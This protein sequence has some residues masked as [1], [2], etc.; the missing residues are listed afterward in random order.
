MED[1]MTHRESTGAGGRQKRIDGKIPCA[2]GAACKFNARGNCTFG[3][4]PGEREAATQHFY[5]NKVCPRLQKRGA[6]AAHQ[7]GKCLFKHPPQAKVSDLWRRS[8]HPRH[9]GTKP[10]RYGANCELGRHCKFSHPDPK[11]DTARRERVG[12]GR[13]RTARSPRGATSLTAAPEVGLTGVEQLLLAEREN[14][15]AAA[16]AEPALG[17]EFMR[18]ADPV[19]VPLTPNEIAFPRLN[20]LFAQVAPLAPELGA[21][22]SIPVAF[23]ASMSGEAFPASVSSGEAFP[24]AVSGEAFPAS[25]SSGEAFPASVS[26]GE[27]FPAAVSSGEAFPAAVSSTGDN[28]LDGWLGNTTI[29][30]PQ[31]IQELSEMFHKAEVDTAD[32]FALLFGEFVRE[33][34]TRARINPV[35]ALQGALQDCIEDPTHKVFSKPVVGKLLTAMRNDK[36]IQNLIPK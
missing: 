35:C 6:C 12:M 28:W 26:S 5:G 22:V 19:G 7:L 4:N 13:T 14:A 30:S 25:V 9:F 36:T 21:A 10:C 2:N 34:K 16:P 24:A 33:G 31:T 8:V 17:C 27:A 29:S 15:V 1:A 11:K 23:P 18:Q 32:Q 3:H 20:M